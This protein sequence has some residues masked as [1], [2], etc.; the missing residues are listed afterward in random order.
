MHKTSN[1]T[2][3][4]ALLQLAKDIK[5][6]DNIPALCERIRELSDELKNLADN[7]RNIKP[8]EIMIP[9]C[10]CIHY[11]FSHIAFTN[12]PHITSRDCALFRKSI[13]DAFPNENECDHG[14]KFEPCPYSHE[15]D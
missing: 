3:V 8:A 13:H 2:L 1:E 14:K 9:C 4:L 6:P 10:D 5:S 12:K 7:I 11:K 15:N